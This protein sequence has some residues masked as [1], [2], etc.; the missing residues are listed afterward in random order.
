MLVCVGKL[1][2]INKNKELI[3]LIARTDLKKNRDFPLA[4]KDEKKQ[5]IGMHVLHIRMTFDA[6][7]HVVGAA[8]STRPEDR[9]RVE[10]LEQAGVDALVIVSR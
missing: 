5:L 9:Q 3:S 1:P 4:N 8:V 7:S 10:M 6:G 2:I